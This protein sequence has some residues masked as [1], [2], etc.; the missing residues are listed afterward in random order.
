MLI[1]AHPLFLTGAG[2]AKRFESAQG[3]SAG[4]PPVGTH[5]RAHLVTIALHLGQLLLYAAAHKRYSVAYGS[6]FWHRSLT[7]LR[8]RRLGNLRPL[9]PL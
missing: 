5:L 1:I 7:C 3:P 6:P 9:S 4:S 8:E 2:L